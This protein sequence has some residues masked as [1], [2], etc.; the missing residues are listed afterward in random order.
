[1]QPQKLDNHVEAV[2]RPDAPLLQPTLYHITCNLHPKPQNESALDYV[3][4]SVYEILVLS[5]GPDHN[6]IHVYNTL[7]LPLDKVFW[8]IDSDDV[9][10][11]K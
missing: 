7:F 10:D 2:I 5:Q 8:S 4:I 11:I 1:M 9:S 3:D 6:Q